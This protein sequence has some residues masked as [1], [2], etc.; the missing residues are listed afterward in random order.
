MRQRLLY[1]RFSVRWRWRLV[2]VKRQ[3]LANGRSWHDDIRL[4]DRLTW[5][6]SCVDER[7]PH[8]QGSENR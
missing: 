7:V 5:S 6:L 2:D 1:W 4:V 3:A 8:N